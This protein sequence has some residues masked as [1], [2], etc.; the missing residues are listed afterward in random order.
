MIYYYDY[1]EFMFFIHKDM[2][3]DK[4]LLA[5]GATK[6]YARD[7]FSRLYDAFASEKIDVIEEYETFYRVEYETLGHYLYHRWNMT[8][9]T[10][11]EIV[12]TVNEQPDLRFFRRVERSYAGNQLR[13]FMTEDLM[14]AR[15]KK[16]LLMKKN[17]AVT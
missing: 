4:F 15:I 9:E 14:F 6:G 17:D 16:I 8:A 7:M 13:R 10:A 2:D 1:F 12:T 11:M 3:R 5:A